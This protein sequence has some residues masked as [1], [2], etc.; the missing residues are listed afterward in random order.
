MRNIEEKE[1]DMKFLQ[2]GIG[3]ND[4]EGVKITCYL[5][6]VSEHKQRYYVVYENGSE[7]LGCTKW[8]DNFEPLEE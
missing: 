1:N 3:W 8:V 4:N 5:V 2:K 6:S 7:S